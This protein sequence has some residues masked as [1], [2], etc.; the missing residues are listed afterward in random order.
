[1]KLKLN[2]ALWIIFLHVLSFNIFSIN[3]DEYPGSS[4]KNLDT[5]NTYNNVVYVRSGNSICTG[6]LINSRTVITA[7]HCLKLGSPVEVLFGADAE[8]PDLIIKATS[9][10]ANP[11]D[12]RYASFQGASYDVALISL[13]TP[14]YSIAPLKLS[15]GTGSLNENVTI[16]GYGLH[17]SGLNPDQAFDGKKRLATNNL[18]IISK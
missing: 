14:V 10:I 18:E 17:G 16:V 11:E 8:D 6:S 15:T 9:F 2:T 13:E 4:D 5:E 1:M 12:N 7:A 3:I